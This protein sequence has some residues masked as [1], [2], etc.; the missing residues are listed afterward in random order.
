MVEPTRARVLPPWLKRTIE[1]G[2][3]VAFLAVLLVTH[4]FRLATWVVIVG[5]GLALAASL[6]VEGRVAPIPMVTGVMALVF[7]GL[8]LALRRNDILQ[9]KMTIVDTL[10]GAILFG[11]LA[12]RK[13]PL[14][15]L[16]G[17]AFSLPE[18]AWATLAVRYGLFWWACAAMNEYVRRTQ[19]V[20]TWAMFR[21]LA[22]IAAIVFALAQTPFLLKHGVAAPPET[23]EPPDPGF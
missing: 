2:P 13:N 12:I 7:G 4:N 18:K 5:A 10:L 20:E 8:S 11:G 15:M 9:M 17:G 21:V 6:L 22:I 23:P 14:K 1:A 16:L 19:S 3:A